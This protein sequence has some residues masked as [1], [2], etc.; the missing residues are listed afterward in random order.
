M[1]Q[2]SVSEDIRSI[3]DP[4]FGTEG[5][6]LFCYEWGSTLDGGEIDKQILVLDTE[7]I[8]ADLKEVY[9]QPTFVIMVRG[10]DNE[11]GKVVYDRARPIYE[12]MIQ[13]LTQEI[14]GTDYLQFEPIGGLI[15][16][17]KDDNNRFT[18]SMT[19]YTFR[20]SI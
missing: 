19:F 7:A 9:E 4:T 3:L 12:F 1:T 14:N 17:G 6:D 15:P 8:D 5:T 20:N 13:A 10:G 18:Y 2:T 11:S 16:L